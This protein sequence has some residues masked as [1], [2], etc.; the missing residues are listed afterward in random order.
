MANSIDPHRCLI[1]LK[2]PTAAIR[3]A[4]SNR[5]INSLKVYLTST[6]IA[7]Q[8]RMPIRFPIRVPNCHHSDLIVMRNW[9]IRIVDLD[10][11]KSNKRQIIQSPAF[12]LHCFDPEIRLPLKNRHFFYFPKLH[13]APAFSIGSEIWR[14][15]PLHVGV[16]DDSANSATE[17]IQEI[18]NSVREA[19]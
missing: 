19:N 5:P 10:A 16:P 6:S 17:A 15:D 9:N 13:K 11:Q 8:N 12:P 3:H 7:A 2:E 14:V 1:A 4:S 18:A